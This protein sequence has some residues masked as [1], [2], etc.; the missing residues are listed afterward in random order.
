MI[1]RTNLKST[2]TYFRFKLKT[3]L[4]LFLILY[5]PTFWG[6]TSLG[7]GQLIYLF[8]IIVLTLPFF[9]ETKSY[10][11]PLPTIYK[12]FFLWSLTY[13][14][15]LAIQPFINNE[16]ILKDFS[17]ILR[18][19]FYLYFFIIGYVLGIKLEK[20]YFLVTSVVVLTLLSFIFDILK[21]NES[22]QAITN[23]YAVFEYGELNYI[24][25][26]GTFGFCYNFGFVCLFGYAI[27][28]TFYS[29]KAITFFV[30]CI[31]MMLIGS[32]SVILAFIIVTLLYFFV[33][34]KISALKKTIIIPIVI[35]LIIFLYIVAV[36]WEI[37]V[38]SDSIKYSERLI[39]ALSGKEADG[40]L[41][42][43]SGQLAVAIERLLK[44]ILFGVGPAKNNYPI[45]IQLG[46]Y[47]S[48][49]GII[50][51]IVFVSIQLNFFVVAARGLKLKDSF[52]SKFSTANLLW[53]ISALIVGM[54]TPI[55]DQI[56]VFQLYF[57]IQ[58]YQYGIIRPY[59]HYKS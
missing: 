57:L 7:T 1:K 2:S 55:T 48:S 28:L 27:A 54:S 33:F 24:R 46:Y 26:S 39:N 40:S 15:T 6:Y 5:F 13:I 34:S 8:A 30:S 29:H 25:Y 56:R 18:P 41:G 19:L 50:G 31:V 11:F 58:G 51:T 59:R 35:A 23:L 32:R 44:S 45:E 42:T 10:R 21:F 37:P 17:D 20:S 53:L 12:L 14:A 43:R 49:W 36:T 47:L 38:V 52:I 3:V 4:L 9:L 22:F 16:I